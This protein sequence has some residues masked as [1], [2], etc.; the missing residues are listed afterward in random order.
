M[1]LIEKW[2]IEAINDLNVVFT[3]EEV[4]DMIISKKGNSLHIGSN[5]QLASYFRRYGYR[6]GPM[7]YR[8]K[9]T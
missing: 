8:R 3:V 5:T 2:V 9:R 4:R 7:T 1:K 6:V